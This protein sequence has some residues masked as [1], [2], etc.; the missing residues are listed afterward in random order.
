MSELASI[1]IPVSTGSLAADNRDKYP[2]DN[3]HGIWLRYNK[4]HVSIVCGVE[5]NKSVEKR[6]YIYSLITSMKVVGIY[7]VPSRNLHIFTSAPPC[8]FAGQLYV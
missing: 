2:P 7:D 3:V 1:T 5:Q 6:R 4:T 8:A